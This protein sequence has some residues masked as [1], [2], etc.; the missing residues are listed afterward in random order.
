MGYKSLNFFATADSYG[1]G[2]P[3]MIPQDVICMNFMWLWSSML[4]EYAVD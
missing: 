2:L 4:E 1:C 3:C